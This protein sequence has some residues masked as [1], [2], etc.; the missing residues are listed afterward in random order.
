M[1]RQLAIPG[2]ARQIERPVRSIASLAFVGLLAAAFWAGAAYVGGM[3][4]T[5][6]ASPF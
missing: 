5:V 4:L 6:G 1:R 2:V 3:F